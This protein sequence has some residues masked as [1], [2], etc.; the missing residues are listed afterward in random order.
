MFDDTF[1]LLIDEN[2]S[3]SSNST[4]SFCLK[5][6][7]DESV[8]TKSMIALKMTLAIDAKYFLDR[9]RSR[10]IDSM[11]DVDSSIVSIIESARF[12]LVRSRLVCSDDED[13][14]L[15]DMSFRST[16]DDKF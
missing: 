2:T 16:S 12:E 11:S 13:S 4:I 6:M 7:N 10:F 1:F 3:F 9:S 8:L 5:E 14:R 15:D